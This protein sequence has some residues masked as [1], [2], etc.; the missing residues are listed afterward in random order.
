[1]PVS[2]ARVALPTAAAVGA[3]VVVEALRR[4]RS[5]CAAAAEAR[6]L[7]SLLSTIKALDKTAFLVVTNNAGDAFA[8]KALASYVKK[9]CGVASCGSALGDGRAL[10]ARLARAAPARARDFG[11]AR[12]ALR[13]KHALVRG[14]IDPALLRERFAAVKAAY[15]QQPLDYG[16]HSRYGDRW[17]ISCYLVVLEKW[18]PK[19]LPHAPMVD[20]MGDVMHACCRGFERWYAERFDLAKC[21]A[22][23]MNC[24]LTRYRPRPDEDELKKHIDGANVDGSVILALPTDDPFVGG[25]LKVWDG[26]RPPK[27]HVYAMK[28]GDCIFLDTRVWHQGCPISTGERYALVLFL[29]LQKTRAPP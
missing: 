3:L 2:A 7:A 4:R 1:M 5:A 15:V 12:D 25:Q 20:A 10:A 18:K 29:K 11:P 23:V 26:G 19:I 14:A 28:P 6:E 9:K 17:K 21:D 24:F 22:T 16:R 8:E 13:L 27:E